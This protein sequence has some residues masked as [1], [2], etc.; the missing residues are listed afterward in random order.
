MNEAM[1]IASCCS[2]DLKLIK[3]PRLAVGADAVIIVFAGIILP[4]PPIKKRV[5]IKTAHAIG[6]KDI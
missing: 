3:L 2:I 1:A 5:V 6:I 4:T